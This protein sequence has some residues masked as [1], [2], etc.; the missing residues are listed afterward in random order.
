MASAAAS[1]RLGDPI[2]AS[3]A[4]TRWSTVLDEMN[5]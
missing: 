5:S 2:F 4:E 1:S 3:T